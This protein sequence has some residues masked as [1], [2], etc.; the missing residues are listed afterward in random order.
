M[1][2]IFIKKF[3]KDHLN[4]EVKKHHLYNNEQFTL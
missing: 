1:N 4:K 2:G 3:I